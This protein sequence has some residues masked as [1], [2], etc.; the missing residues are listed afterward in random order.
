MESKI[1]VFSSKS[2]CRQVRDSTQYSIYFNPLTSSAGFR[3]IDCVDKI[4]KKLWGGGK[5]E[6]PNPI[7]RFEVDWL[8]INR[9]V[10]GGNV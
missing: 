6:F 10:F 7:C 3:H 9:F 2:L 4:H 8:E 5:V 1:F